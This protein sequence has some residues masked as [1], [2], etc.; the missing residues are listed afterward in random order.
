MTDPVR[1]DQ[2]IL[3]IPGGE[4]PVGVTAPAPTPLGIER[5]LNEVPA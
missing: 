3:F 4:F 2:T 1:T 5:I